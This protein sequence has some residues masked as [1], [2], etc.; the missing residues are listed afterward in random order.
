MGKSLTSQAG[1]GP[2]VQRTPVGEIRSREFVQ[3]LERGL[4]VI[5][6]FSSDAPNL[7]IAQ[8]ADRT[9]LTRA[10]RRAWRRS[11]SEWQADDT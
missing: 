4:A 11:S 2:A 1:R 8:V 9:G 7:T 5:L 3:G 6:S 10:E